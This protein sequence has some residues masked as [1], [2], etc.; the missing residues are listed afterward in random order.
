MFALS[1]AIGRKSSRPLKQKALTMSVFF[2]FF[3]QSV[4]ICLRQDMSI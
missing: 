2:C 4:D 3:F 1:R